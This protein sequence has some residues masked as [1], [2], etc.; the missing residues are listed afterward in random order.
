[1]EG[2]GTHLRH[3]A[4]AITGTV[5]EARPGTGPMMDG[6]LFAPRYTMERMILKLNC[7]SNGRSGPDQPGINMPLR[8]VSSIITT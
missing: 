6:A 7:Q 3:M 1:M 5:A 2:P 8:V 4:L